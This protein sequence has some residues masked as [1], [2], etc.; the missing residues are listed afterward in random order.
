MGRREGA[1][2]AVAVEQSDSFVLTEPLR[3][4]V[5]RA[6]TYLNAGYP[7]H[8]SGPSGIGKTTLALHI[9]ALR[10]RPVALL[11]GDHELG[12]SDL[13]GGECGYQRTRV[14]DNYVRS[15]MKTEERVSLLWADNQLTLAC[16]HGH[17][18][19]YDEFTRSRPETNN[20]M[21]SVLEEKLL[22]LPRRRGQGE[23][24]VEVHPA[25]RAIFTSNP[26]EYAGVHRTQDAL[27]DRLITIRLDYPDRETEA[28]VTQARSGLTAEDAQVIVD[29]VQE[30]R[31]SGQVNPKPSLRACVMIARVLQQEGTRA[32]AD[33]P[34]F[35]DVCR[36]VLCGPIVSGPA[37][38]STSELWA[39][40]EPILVRHA[41]APGVLAQGLKGRRA[42]ARLPLA[43][44]ILTE[45]VA[46]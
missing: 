12:S 31:R 15:V 25:F 20:A 46:T 33:N 19:L 26:E 35:V 44:A 13:T 3:R 45:G 22:T 38:G 27:R 14:V 24:F 42:E 23:D 18:L 7:V 34:F 29:I 11:H 17:T 32:R 37:L 21:L 36:D 6:L 5:R 28:R 1:E 9:A 30:L 39:R 43:E 2:S 40:L 8:L 16:R 41:P 10:G 4:I